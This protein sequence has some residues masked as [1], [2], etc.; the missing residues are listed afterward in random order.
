[1]VRALFSPTWRRSW[2]RSTDK[3]LLLLIAYLSQHSLHNSLPY[4]HP[5]TPS[6]RPHPHPHPRKL[7]KVLLSFQISIY[8]LPH[9]SLLEI[10]H[11][12]ERWCR[13]RAPFPARARA[14][15]RASARLS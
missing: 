9:L 6:P 10:P 3:Y 2:C 14:R 13:Q 1:M 11:I 15:A 8:H 12:W 7:R 5:A 4:Y